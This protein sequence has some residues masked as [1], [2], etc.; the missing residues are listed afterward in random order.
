MIPGNK[1]IVNEQDVIKDYESGMSTP[2]LAR[3]Y[4]YKTPKSINDL[5]RRN[6]VTPRSVLDSQHL[7]KGYHDLK[8]NVVDSELKA[9]YIGLLI[10]DGYIHEERKPYIELTLEDEDVISFLA[11]TFHTNYFPCRTRDSKRKT[12]YRVVLYGQSLVD[13]IKRYGLI[14]SKSFTVG[15]LHLLK[16]EEKFIPY[17]LRG[18]IDGDGWIRKDGKEF[19]LCGA[20][21]A[22]ITWALKAFNQLGFL[23]LRIKDKPQPK[24]CHE[25][26][27]IRSAL[28]HN[29]DLLKSIIYDKPFGMAR[30]YNRLHQ[31]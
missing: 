6:G 18:A 8:L 13:D 22:F 24:G 27:E 4:G 10:T 30:K 20:S 26:Y 15:D 19:F 17:I 28:V 1:K 3:K 29:I 9:Y 12:L 7:R 25:M 14:Q 2:Q 23:G 11:N 21:I 16:E 31:V 5:L